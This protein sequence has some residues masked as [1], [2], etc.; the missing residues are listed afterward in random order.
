MI[1]TQQTIPVES[2]TAEAAGLLTR[3]FDHEI[4]FSKTEALDG[5]PHVFRA[6]LIAGLPGSPRSVIIKCAQR[7]E[8][9]PFDPDDQSPFSLTASFFNEWAGLQF[10]SDILGD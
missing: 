10:L 3:T 9:Q 1:G 2:I 7:S 6:S 4:R 8:D 5:R